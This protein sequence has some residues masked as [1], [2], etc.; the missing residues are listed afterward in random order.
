MRSARRSEGG[1]ERGRKRKIVGG[2]VRAEEHN[3]RK[4]Q[5]LEEVM[6][7]GECD[8]SEM[9]RAA[10]VDDSAGVDVGV[11]FDGHKA[12]VD[13]DAAADVDDHD[14]NHNGPSSTHHP[15]SGPTHYPSGLPI[16]PNEARD[17]SAFLLDASCDRYRQA[18]WAVHGGPFDR[19]PPGLSLLYIPPGVPYYIS[20]LA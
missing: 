15:S 4:E 3:S 19:C 13:V 1:R 8:E 10:G 12:A 11:G 7:E 6:M 9:N 20:P 17:L 2:V 14:D 5:R 16:L 18:I